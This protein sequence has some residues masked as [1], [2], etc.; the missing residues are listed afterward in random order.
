MSGR[1]HPIEFCR[2]LSPFFLK[3][4]QFYHSSLSLSGF[5]QTLSDTGRFARDCPGFSTESRVPCP[6]K[7]GGLLNEPRGFQRWQTKVLSIH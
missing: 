3:I 5:S 7:L 4:S 2:I 1:S 6:E